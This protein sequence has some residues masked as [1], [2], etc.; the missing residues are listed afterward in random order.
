M[1]RYTGGRL[2]VLTS[3]PC[4]WAIY[5]GKFC[6]RSRGCRDQ[7]TGPEVG[8][9]GRPQAANFFLVYTYFTLNYGYLRHVFVHYILY[10][11]PGIC[12]DACKRWN[13]PHRGD[14]KA[15]VI[16]G[17]RKGTSRGPHHASIWRARLHNVGLSAHH[18]AH[19]TNRRSWKDLNNY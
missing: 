4:Q 7:Y 10:N 12:S 5:S 2:S 19:L 1:I 8:R 15:E 6:W 9:E 13:R 3:T 14:V 11:D 16:V 18:V 17:A